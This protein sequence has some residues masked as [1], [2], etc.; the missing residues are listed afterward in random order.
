[1]SLNFQFLRKVVTS[2]RRHRFLAEFKVE[3]GQLSIDSGH[4]VAEIAGE[5]MLRVA[6]LAG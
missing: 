3:A 4:V 6:L 2:S 1:M 5:R